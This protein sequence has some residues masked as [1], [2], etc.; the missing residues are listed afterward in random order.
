M[1]YYKETVIRFWNHNLAIVSLPVALTQKMYITDSKAFVHHVEFPYRTRSFQVM[2]VSTQKMTYQNDT[3]MLVFSHNSP[4]LACFS[5]NPE[6][7]N[8]DSRV[9]VWCADRLYM[10]YSF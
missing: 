7:E 3:A 10:P 8:S 5:L 6:K 1:L 2:L 9:A 4:I